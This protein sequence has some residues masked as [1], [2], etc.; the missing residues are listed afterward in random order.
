MY[1]AFIFHKKV[2]SLSY[3]NVR[4][5]N[6]GN[7]SIAIT[8]IN[9]ALFINF[10]AM[11]YV[12]R[13]GR[14]TKFPRKIVWPLIV[15]IAQIVIGFEHLSDTFLHSGTDWQH[16]GQMGTKFVSMANLYVEIFSQQWNYLATSWAFYYYY[17]YYYYTL[18]DDARQQQLTSSLPSPVQC[19]FGVVSWKTASVPK[20]DSL[21]EIL[22]SR[23]FLTPDDDS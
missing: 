12:E 20:S 10:H 18:Y 1:A 22:I 8:N 16:N 9:T 5:F 14:F 7:K 6:D 21:P 15:L 11:F 13:N 4:V 17:F 2:I 23:A 3:I 19:A